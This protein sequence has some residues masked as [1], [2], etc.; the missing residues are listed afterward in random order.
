MDRVSD[1]HASPS[2]HSSLLLSL[3]GLLR[4]NRHWPLSFP[5]AAGGIAF[6]MSPASNRGRGF[7]CGNSLQ[8]AVI[9]WDREPRRRLRFERQRCSWRARREHVSGMPTGTFCQDV[10]EH[11]CRNV[12]VLRQPL[13]SVTMTSQW[14]M[15]RRM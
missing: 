10:T 14:L 5:K 6:H 13:I 2:T 4:I 15:L 8:R 7:C 3:S 1:C 11:L 12:F 9:G